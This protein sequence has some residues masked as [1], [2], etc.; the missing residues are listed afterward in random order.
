MRDEQAS[1]SNRYTKQ[2]QVHE[3]LAFVGDRALRQN[4]L[5]LPRRHQA[6]RECQRAENHF[7][8]QNRHHERRYVGRAQIKFGG[9]DQ[10]HAERAKR[11]AE[12]RPLRHGG[13]RDFAERYAD[14][15]AENKRNDDPFVLDDAVIQQRAGNGQQHADF[16]SEDAAACGCRRT[17]PLQR[18]NKKRGRDQVGDFDEVFRRHAGRS[19]PL[20]ASLA[21]WP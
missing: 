5:Q 12:R 7:H 20:R 15:G 11:M 21:R 18:K 13:H 1:H 16:S 3:V 8:R 2:A 6:A 19:L 4:F 9:A 10:R 17:Q 14:D